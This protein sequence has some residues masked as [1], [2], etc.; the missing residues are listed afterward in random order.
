[1]F[2]LYMVYGLHGYMVLEKFELVMREIQKSVFS[3]VKPHTNFKRD[4]QTV[5][6]TDRAQILH[7]YLGP[8]MGPK[9]L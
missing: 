6:I 8:E 1:M 4:A 7:T 3:H 2:S 5:D 9:K